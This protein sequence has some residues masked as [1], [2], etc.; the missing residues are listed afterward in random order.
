LAHFEHEVFFR[1]TRRLSGNSALYPDLVANQLAPNP[2]IVPV[3]ELHGIPSSIQHA[4]VAMAFGHRIYR[5]AGLTLSTLAVSSEPIH[6]VWWTRLHHHRGLAIHLMNEAIGKVG[7]RASDETITTVLVFL[8]GEVSR[9]DSDLF[10]I[11][12]C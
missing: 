11:C 7:T 12:D 9:A 2:F 5:S 10:S 1:L 4:L 3:L 6:K 8:L